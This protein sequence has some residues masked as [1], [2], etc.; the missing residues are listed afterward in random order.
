MNKVLLFLLL[1]KVKKHMV[2]T[3]L[4]LVAS[5]L[6]IPVFHLTLVTTDVN[7][8]GLQPG[9]FVCFGNIQPVLL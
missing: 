1:E 9:H 5:T 4:T 3:N 2:G 8:P 7:G 6:A